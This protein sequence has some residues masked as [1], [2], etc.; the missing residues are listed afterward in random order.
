M[1]PKK[2]PA[3]IVAENPIVDSFRED[4]LV[5]L[6]T[7]MGTDRDARSYT[8][9]ARKP[10]LSASELDTRFAQGDLE[11]NIVSI[12]VED[13]TREWIDLQGPDDVPA[14]LEAALE[15]IDARGA[16]FE[17]LLWA[18][19]TGGA[20]GVIGLSNQ[21]PYLD[22][23]TKQLPIDPVTR[24]SIN[25]PDLSLPAQ[26]GKVLW[27]Q[28]FDRFEVAE[29]RLN[30]NGDV[31]VYRVTVNGKVVDVHA[32]RCLR[33]NGDPLPRRM[34]ETAGWG[35]SVLDRCKDR[36]DDLDTAINGI[37]VAMSRFSE[38]VMHIGGLTG[39]LAKDGSG[40]VRNKLAL[41]NL[42]RSQYGL[43]TLDADDRLVELSRNF[44]GVSDMLDR[45]TE[46]V[47]SAARMPISLLMGRSPAGLNATGDS[48]LRWWY[49]HIASLQITQMRPPLW[50][51]MTLVAAGENIPLDD[52]RLDFVSLWKPTQGE[53][54][55]MHLT[56]AQSD[57]VYVAMGAMTPDEVRAARFA[58][59]GYSV[60]TFVDD[61]LIEAIDGNPDDIDPTLLDGA[62]QPAGAVV[63]IQKAALNGAQLASAQ[64]IVTAVAKGEMPRDAGIA[65]IELG[66]QL[67]TV[68]ATKI[69]GSAG[70]GFIPAVPLAAG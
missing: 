46:R 55:T 21:K 67:S 69:M 14:R 54:A 16:I 15:A 2:K 10:R 8:F 50:R 40:A 18:R 68:E 11:H 38:T 58:P 22:P 60:E 52:V 32:S 47:A 30:R 28:V 66:F 1:A 63:D 43:M 57:N 70:A 49:A 48:D 59:T 56:Q 24:L 35:L 61:S 19:N 6:F 4:S 9:S 64:A 34:R 36:I 65:L 33:F 23:R 27:V 31:D 51:L 37:G 53:L 45:L 20:V 7:G 44:G 41:L 62:V 39:L 3:A 13:M 17:G 42:M 12:P 5:N 25:E 29:V 26:P